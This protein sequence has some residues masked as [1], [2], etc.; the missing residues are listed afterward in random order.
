MYNYFFLL[1]KGFVKDGS[2]AAF[3]YGYG[4]FNISILPFFSVF[5]L[6][7]VQHFNGV[8]AYPNIRGGG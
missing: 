2:A 5:R 8:L 6:I 4:G 7:F 3:L 1:L